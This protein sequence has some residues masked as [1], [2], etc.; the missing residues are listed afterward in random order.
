MRIN[1]PVTGVEKEL[2]DDTVIVSKTSPKGVIT[3]VNRDFIEVSGFCEAELIGQAHNIVRHPDMPPAAFKDL[4]DTVKAGRPWTGIVK[5]R[6]KNGD[7]YWV[8]ANVTPLRENG[9]VT[10]YMSVRRKA[11][12]AQIANAEAL[13]RSI[14]EGKATLEPKGAAAAVQ[15]SMKRITIR[16]RLIATLGLLALGLLVMGGL[17][18]KNLSD[19]Q[20]SMETVYQDRVVPLKQLKVV[21]DMYAVNIVDTAHKTRNGNLTWEQGLENVEDARRLIDRSWKAYTGTHLV[22]REKELV[23]EAA[24]LLA[25]AD[26]SVAKLT[27][28]MRRRDAQAIAD[29]SIRELYPVIDPISGK[30]SELVDMQLEGPR[31]RPRPAP[32]AT[33]TCR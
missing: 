27:D 20:L 6:C 22:D 21:A 23:A 29:Y 33:V 15:R 5:N 10:G 12:R 28:I 1:N 13:Y 26:A 11:S 32:R 14:N 3:Y 9:I 4:W 7:H 16:T 2:R 25:A 30:V 31:P 17:G 24:P 19:A 8:E 18:M